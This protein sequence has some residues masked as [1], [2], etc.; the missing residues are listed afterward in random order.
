[1]KN[2]IHTPVALGIMASLALIFSLVFVSLVQ[3]QSSRESMEKLVE[4][5]NIKTAAASDMRDAIRL[6][7][8]SSRP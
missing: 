8:E 4:A 3:L 2:D 7:S 1:M 5:T 6:R